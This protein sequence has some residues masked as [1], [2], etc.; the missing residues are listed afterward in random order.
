MHIR[1]IKL[2]L[3]LL[4]IIFS[5]NLFA[6]VNAL[7]QKFEILEDLSQT[8]DESSSLNDMFKDSNS[9]WK[10]IS[11]GYGLKEKKSKRIQKKIRKYEKWY[12]QRPEYMERM[13]KRSER[14]LYYVANEVKKRNMPMEIAL[15]PMI[16][17]AYNPIAKSNKKAVGLWQFI[18]STGKIYKLEQN[19]WIDDR[20]SVINATDAAL[21]YLEKLYKDFG[22]WEHALA[23][24]NAGEGRVGRSIKNNKRRKRSTDYY[25]LKLP[26]ETR[27]YVPKLIAIRNIIKNPS[28]YNVYLPTIQNTPYFS[29]VILPKK[30]DTELIPKFAEI[31]MEEFQYLNAEYKRPLMN[32]TASSQY[33][34]LPV[35]SVTQFNI[36]L[37]SYDKPLASWEVYKPKKG[38]RINTV[39]KKFGIDS[40]LIRQVNRL[41]GRKTFRRNSIVLLPKRSSLSTDFALN[42]KGLY[43][44]DSIITHHVSAGDTLGYLSKKYKISLKDL[45][46]FNELDSHMIIIGT[47]IDIPQ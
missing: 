23:A 28:K 16:E 36:N 27:N 45:M 42:N 19:W 24:Y 29:K 43:S 20:K 39:A 18:S 13:L 4:S 40:K 47:T 21:N 44:Y 37:F 11:S 26:R 10:T 35:S 14:Y 2:T 12:S 31:S 7:G 41:K 33:V 15:L 34:L 38:E 46:E 6:G 1:L 9:I 32:T 22:T 3:L 30:I 5:V 17:S 8:E 25:S